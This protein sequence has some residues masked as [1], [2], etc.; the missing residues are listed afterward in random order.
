MLCLEFSYAHLPVCDTLPA[1]KPLDK[2]FKNSASDGFPG[3]CQQFCFSARLIHNDKHLTSS[4]N[5]LLC[6]SQS[7]LNLVKFNMINL[8]MYI[9]KNATGNFVHYIMG[10][11]FFKVA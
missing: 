4:I 8:N 9:V 5:G 11:I 10:Y 3:T 6:A 1:P 7:N 2:Y